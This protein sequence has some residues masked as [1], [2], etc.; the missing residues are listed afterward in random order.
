MLYLKECKRDF[1]AAII[2]NNQKLEIILIYITIEWW[3]HIHVRLQTM[4][5]VISCYRTHS[6]IPSN[7]SRIGETSQWCY[8]PGQF[9]LR[10]GQ[11]RGMRR[12]SGTLVKFSCLI[13]LEVHTVWKFT[14]MY[15]YVRS[16]MC[17]YFISMSSYNQLSKCEW[18]FYLI[19]CSEGWKFTLLQ[20]NHIL[21]HIRNLRHYLL[22]SDFLGKEKHNT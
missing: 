1:A 15:T 5:K 11:L 20:N 6:M 4:K 9:P 8:Q 21:F 13:W 18:L 19:F 2:Q 7:G 12:T 17:I 14:E 10:Q 16:F 22:K 3:G